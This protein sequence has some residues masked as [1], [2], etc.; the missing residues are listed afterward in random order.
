MVHPESTL[1]IILFLLE[2]VS[3]SNVIVR[4]NIA[5][6]F[7]CS[8]V[9]GL[10]ATPVSSLRYM[11]QNKTKQNEKKNTEKSPVI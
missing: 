5:R 1:T 11:I 7:T 10:P 6:T 3:D 9:C 2:I 4:G 8:G